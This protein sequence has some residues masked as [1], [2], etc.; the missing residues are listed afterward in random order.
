MQ[1]QN[2]GRFMDAFEAATGFA[3]MMSSYQSTINPVGLLGTQATIGQLG[4]AFQGTRGISVLGG[5]QQGFQ[6]SDDFQRAFLYKAL[7]S[8]E[9][10]RGI[11]PAEFV[12]LEIRRE[13]GLGVGTNLPDVLRQLGRE[14]YGETGSILALR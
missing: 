1:G 3:Q 8:G 10:S 2:L 7:R 13:Q 5:I 9:R 11:A 4:D 12:D 14:G 6:T